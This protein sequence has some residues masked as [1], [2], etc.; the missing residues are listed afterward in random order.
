M[1]GSQYAH[2]LEYH[3]ITGWREKQYRGRGRGAHVRRF[4]LLHRLIFPVR[5]SLLPGRGG[6]SSISAGMGGPVSHLVL[7]KALHLCVIRPPVF[8]GWELCPAGQEES[9][10]SQL[11]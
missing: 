5:P 1:V 4:Y 6:S 9:S 11:L 10:Q 7:L 2:P 3:Y 8:P